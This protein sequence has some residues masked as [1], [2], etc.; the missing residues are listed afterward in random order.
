MKTIQ[1]RLKGDTARYIYNDGLLPLS[2]HGDATTTRASHVEPAK[3]GGWMV[4]LSPVGGPIIG[5]FDRRDAALSH[6]IDWLLRNKI[7]TPTPQE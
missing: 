2:Q 7:P 4:D 5:P 1:I 6:E 3:N